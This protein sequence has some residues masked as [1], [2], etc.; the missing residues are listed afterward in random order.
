MT[1][2][3]NTNPDTR[4]ETLMDAPNREA[5]VRDLFDSMFKGDSV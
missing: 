1:D 4:S 2:I 5:K 3:P